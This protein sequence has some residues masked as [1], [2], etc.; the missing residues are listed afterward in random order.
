MDTDE[1]SYITISQFVLIIMMFWPYCCLI[2]PPPDLFCSKFA[3]LN[4][5]F[6]DKV[7]HMGMGIISHPTKLN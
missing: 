3:I 4:I 5:T 7:V 6:Q 2:T 1:Y